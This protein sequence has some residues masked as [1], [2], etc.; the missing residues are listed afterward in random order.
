ML[1][2]INIRY[3]SICQI[4]VLLLAACREE[5]LSYFTE[6]S[7][8]ISFKVSVDEGWNTRA[9]AEYGAESLSSDVA[10]E[11]IG[12]LKLQ[13]EG[14]ATDSLFLHVTVSNEICHENAGGHENPTRGEPVS[15]ESFYDSFGLMAGDCGEAF[16]PESFKPNF[17]Y[18][19]EIT[20]SS[21]WE[22]SYLWPKNKHVFKFYAY[23]PYCKPTVGDFDF[24]SVIDNNIRGLVI[25]SDGAE[26][27][28][29]P[30]IIYRMPANTNDQKDLLLA[31]AEI[32]NNGEGES[33]PVGMHFYHALTAVKFVTAPD[34]ARSRIDT[35]AFE[36]YY[37]LASHHIGSDEWT[38]HSMPASRKFSLHQYISG[39]SQITGGS[40]TMMAVPQTLPA[41][42]KLRVVYRPE[43]VWEGIGYTA[44]L[45]GLVLPMGKTVTFTLSTSSL[46]RDFNVIGITKTI[47]GSGGKYKVNILSRLYYGDN[48]NGLK[49]D[50]TVRY[51][52][53][54]GN[55][56]S[57]PSWVTSAVRPSTGNDGLEMSIAS[58]TESRVSSTYDDNLKA[59]SFRG[60][61]ASPFNL[62]NSV[63]A[64]TVENTA[65][66]YVVNAPGNYSLPLVYGNAVK[67]GTNNET[68]YKC[69]VNY[70]NSEKVLKVF[71]NHLDREI[72]SP[73]IYENDGCIP[74]DAVLLW[75]DVENL[76]TD[77]KLSEDSR[78]LLFTVLSSNISQG[79]AVV[80]V[81]N[82]SGTVMW[83][84]HIWVTGYDP[85]SD[86]GCVT[87][88]GKSN[89]TYYLM[90]ENLG[91]CGKTYEYS[92]DVRKLKMIF[93]QTGS[94][95]SYS[96]EIEQRSGKEKHGRSM[97]YNWGRKDPLI[98]Y[99]TEP[100]SMSY[101][102]GATNSMLHKKGTQYSCDKPFALNVVSGNTIGSSIRM[103][104]ISFRLSGAYNSWYHYKD[105]NSNSKNYYIYDRYVNLWTN[106]Y[107][108]LDSEN[109]Y[110]VKTIYDPCPVGFCVPPNDLWWGLVSHAS[111]K[112]IPEQ[113]DPCSI[114]LYCND[115]QADQSIVY[116]PY[117][118][119][120]NNSTTWSQ[121]YSGEVSAMTNL[122][123]VGPNG[124]PYL[125]RIR[126]D[127]NYNFF[128][129]LG[130]DIDISANRETNAGENYL[131]TVRP[132]KEK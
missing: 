33:Q 74:A 72:T 62:S 61:L 46:R 4:V 69:N 84:W 34:F 27:T 3:I 97:Y 128:T 17:F 5:T 78:S 26:R 94:G 91:W 110:A 38:G 22:S 6:R 90:K 77:V 117:T 113:K 123:S 130:S 73:Y 24:Q 124:G 39:N 96:A 129:P 35:I 86:D 100:S 67:N 50:W 103:P 63:G 106:N 60:S 19:E 125:F 80:A 51:V 76:I 18:D 30:E 98:Y 49:N 44:D 53:D 56:I 54:E 126:P 114:G 79:N 16:N 93:T 47:G 21:G 37:T 107:S 64:E 40:S 58:M 131:Q 8:R 59:A 1:K 66:C 48:K 2:R 32:Q 104:T 88:K 12:V 81:R 99:Y 87:V 43:G 122:T 28:G 14:D 105:V 13:A 120:G 65:N 29:V 115:D 89:G 31:S 55:T 101:L 132:M 111:A 71:L 83:S 85:Y 118:L 11:Y 23:A 109:Q 112:G 68:A 45:E 10:E 41:G 20:Y 75:Q 9:S 7:E 25:P 82:S 108:R 95:T 102:S 36:K 57:R 70:N 121:I 52:D 127:E 92:G 116:F 119:N 42:A 15:T